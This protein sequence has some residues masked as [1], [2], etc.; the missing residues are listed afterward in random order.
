MDR[1]VIDRLNLLK[2]QQ[3][4]MTSLLETWVNINSGTDNI[5]GL[6]AM[7]TALRDAF[8]SLGGILTEIPLPKRKKVDSKGDLIEIPLG[9]ALTVRK[10]PD[11][12]VQILLA[13]HMDTVYPVD[14]PFQR[15]TFFDDS[16]MKG[17]GAADMKGGLLIMLKALQTLESSP[18][19]GQVG[20]E[21][22]INSDEEVG[23][24]GSGDLFAKRAPHFDAALIF[25]PSFSDGYLVSE[26]KGSTNFSVVARG[27]AAHSGRDF[28][29]GRNAIAAI[30]RLIVKVDRL[31]H[32]EK[33]LT[34]NVGFVEGGGPVN[35][36]PDLAICKINIRV[37]HN[38]DFLTFKTALDA[39][40]AEENRI[41]G[42]SLTCHEGIYRTTKPFDTAH[43]ALF[44]EMR[45]CAKELGHEL[46]WRPSGGVCDG[47]IL[48]GAGLP[49]IDTLGAIGGNIHTSEEYVRLESLPERAAL[50]ALFLMKVAAGEILLKQEHTHDKR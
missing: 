43:E 25:E 5:A 24:P 7:L 17:P 41:E 20:W 49:T 4:E 14:H 10:H 33:G 40:V 42:I 23:S 18:Y 6:G 28:H 37:T 8:A 30:A 22:L 15:A 34:V 46:H 44:G 13:G 48:S 26:R 1:H 11:A 36:V 45:H 21:V 3:A 31:N 38:D 35:I 2:T 32:P 27:K 12:P 16:L 19:A 50:T 29:L 9:N 39:I 47:N